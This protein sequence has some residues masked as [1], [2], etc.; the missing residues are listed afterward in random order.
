[1]SKH[2]AI[3]GGTSGIG[4]A[5]VAQLQ[6]DGHTVYA[7]CR[8]PEKLAD[9][10]I[11]AQPF[12][13]AAPGPLTWPERLD[14]FVYF[15][16][17]ISLK[18]FHRL[19]AEDFQRD[20][21]VNLFGAIAAL[22][23][24]L[25]ALKAS[26]N[27]SVVLFS[28]VAVAQGMPMHA[29]ISAAKGAVEGL[30]KSLA[31]EWAPAIRVNVI[32]PSLTDTPLAGALLNSDLKKEAAAKRHPLQQVGRSEDMAALVAHLLSGH[33]RFMTGQVLHVDGGLSSVRTF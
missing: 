19:T 30:A 5:T 13:A 18:P 8:S 29:S 15:P 3:I 7:A 22:Q 25:P 31:A 1:M 12:D 16:G 32:A 20:L 9:L 10:D 21:Q 14:G 27:A 26:G 11:V 17:S 24:A 6:A 2:I 4:R 33:A 28:T 23:S